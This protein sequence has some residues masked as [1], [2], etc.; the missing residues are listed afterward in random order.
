MPFGGSGMQGSM[1]GGGFAGAQGVPA[2][3]ARPRLL[4]AGGGFPTGVQQGGGVPWRR[5]TAV[6]LR[7][8]L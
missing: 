3:G 7:Q 6:A 2:Q 5:S 4:A 1:S 8:A